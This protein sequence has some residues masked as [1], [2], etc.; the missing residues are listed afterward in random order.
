L[1]VSAKRNP[2]RPTPKLHQKSTGAGLL[3]LNGKST[4][5]S[6]VRVVECSVGGVVGATARAVRAVPRLQ[7]LGLANTLSSGAGRL[8]LYREEVVPFDR[9]S[10]GALP[11]VEAYDDPAAILSPLSATRRDTAQGKSNQICQI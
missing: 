4:E 11:P 1:S 7:L 8:N 6:P 5:G 2:L 10:R 9:G 3:I